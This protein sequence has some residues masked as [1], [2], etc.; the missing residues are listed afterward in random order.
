MRKLSHYQHLWQII[1][2]SW[3]SWKIS[4][5]GYNFVYDS[6]IDRFYKPFMIQRFYVRFTYKPERVSNCFS[7]LNYNQHILGKI[8]HK[9]R[10]WAQN[11]TKIIGIDWP[12]ASFCKAVTSSCVLGITSRAPSAWHSVTASKNLTGVVYI[13]YLCRQGTSLTNC[14]CNCQKRTKLFGNQL[15]QRGEVKTQNWDA[16]IYF[17]LSMAV[18][19]RS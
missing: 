5:R 7:K 19:R 1:E 4:G 6:D 9:L 13:L 3:E 16:W 11:R 10:D 12:L 18:M 8:H 15:R 14:F 17:T 2:P